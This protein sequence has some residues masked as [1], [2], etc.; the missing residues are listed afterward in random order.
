MIGMYQVGWGRLHS[1]TIVETDTF[2]S[3]FSRITCLVYIEERFRTEEEV[4]QYRQ[5]VLDDS[6]SFV[7]YI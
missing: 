2:I 1:S 3:F 6:L 7:C 4:G 5:Q